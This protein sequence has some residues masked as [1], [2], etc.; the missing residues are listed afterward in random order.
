M[1]VFLTGASGVMGRS[2]LTALDRAGHEVVGLARSERAARI[3]AAHGAHVHPGTVFDRDGL[4]AGM[5]GCDAVLHFATAMPVG[6]AMLLPGPWRRHDRIRGAGTRAVV[7]AVRAAGV[8]RLVQ[9]SRSALYADGGD[10]W[11]DEYSPVDI[12]RASDPIA[13]AESAAAAARADG[14]D[15]VILRFGQIAGPDP[16]S[17]WLVR[18]ARS[19]R[20]TGWGEPR[21]WMHP[22][23]VDDVGTAAVAALSAPDG[24][25][26][27]GGEPCRRADLAE[28][29]AVAG[30]RAGGRFHH[31]FTQRMVG[32]RL[33]TY[34]RSQRVSSQRFADRTG[35][36]PEH[37]KLTPDWFDD[38]LL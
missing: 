17:R 26:N 6:H 23:H 12:T 33:E 38:V 32:E 7:D 15:V 14:V 9:Q 2:A 28:L 35:W 11:V 3:I 34:T 31:P 24:L 13:D 18:R 37:P 8:P 27:V 5:R 29:L 22:V 36:H 25:Y 21:S 4:A 20:P 16:A 10:D 19:G 30:G 1:K